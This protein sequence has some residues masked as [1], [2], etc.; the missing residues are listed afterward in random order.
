LICVGVAMPDAPTGKGGRSVMRKVGRRLG[1]Y[2]TA[3]GRGLRPK[4]TSSL[5]PL[6]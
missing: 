4:K 5:A 6:L 3:R 2:F 1:P